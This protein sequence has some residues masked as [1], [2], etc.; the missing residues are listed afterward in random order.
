[1]NRSK[2]FLKNLLKNIKTI[3]LVGA[4]SNP[5]RDSYKVMKYLIDKNYEVLPVNPKEANKKIL[6]RKCFSSLND[7]KFIISKLDSMALIS[8]LSSLLSTRKVSPGSHLS[9][10]LAIFPFKVI[11][12]STMSLS[13]D[14]LEY[15]P[16]MESSF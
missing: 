6:G 2:E 15:K 16:I 14:L 8:T 3:A 1:M 10:K 13:A 7:R 5:R 12:P 11:L 4:S 9:P